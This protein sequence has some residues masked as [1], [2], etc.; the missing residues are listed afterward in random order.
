MS[1]EGPW[2]IAGKHVKLTRRDDEYELS[3]G[4]PSCPIFGSATWHHRYVLPRVEP[5]GLRR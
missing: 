4:K 3:V 1:W 5:S 2:A